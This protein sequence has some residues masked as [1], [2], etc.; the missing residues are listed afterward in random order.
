MHVWIISKL[1]ADCGS[2]AG[3]FQNRTFVVVLVQDLV[4]G[5]P[6]VG[7]ANYPMRRGWWGGVHWLY[8]V[9]QGSQALRPKAAAYSLIHRFVQI[10]QDQGVANQAYGFCKD[11]HRSLFLAA[12]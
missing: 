12:D 3:S 6:R 1:G 8:I 4:I 7:R 10:G 2:F 5:L 11:A 9:A